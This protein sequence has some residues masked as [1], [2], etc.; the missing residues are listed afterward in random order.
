[1]K[2]YKCPTLVGP[3]HAEWHCEHLIP[4]ADGGSD[5][6]DNLYPICIPCHK[7]KTANDVKWIAKGKRVR[8]KHEGIWQS[9]RPMPGSRRSPFKRKMNGKIEKR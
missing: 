1:M 5:E 6:A 7:P 3:G 4:R 8:A 2:C 9:S